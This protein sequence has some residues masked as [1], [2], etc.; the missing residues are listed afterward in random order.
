MH[1]YRLDAADGAM[2]IIIVMSFLRRAFHCHDGGKSQCA[3]GD[4]AEEG[5]SIF[6]IVGRITMPPP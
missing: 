4:A 2:I 5:A 1:Y 3:K 6:T